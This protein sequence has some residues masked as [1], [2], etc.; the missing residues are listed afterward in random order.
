ML[1]GLTTPYPDT[2][3]PALQLIKLEQGRSIAAAIYVVVVSGRPYFFADCAV[4]IEPSAEQLAEIAVST[5]AVARDQF[6]VNPRVGFISYSNFGS[7][8]GEEPDRV[9]RGRRTLRRP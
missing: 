8:A 9:R 6:D 2:V 3:R 7:A 4:N 5:A 1:G